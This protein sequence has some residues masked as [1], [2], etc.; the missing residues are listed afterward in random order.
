MPENVRAEIR[1]VSA[2]G[3]QFV[4][5]VPEGTP[6]GR[7]ADGTVIGENRV[8]MPQSIGPVLDQATVLMASIDDA[9]MRRVISES[10]DAFNG[11]ARDLQRF[12]DSA[13]L[14]LEEAQRNT[15]VTRKLIADAEP[16]LD[17][18]LRSSDSIRAWTRNLADVTDQ[19]RENEPQLTSLI[20]AAVPW[21]GL[22]VRAAATCPS[23][24]GLGSVGEVGVITA[25]RSGCW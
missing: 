16:V 12:I 14:L 9:K 15:D 7:L 5:F 19:L 11:S 8:D 17:S 25:P 6:E 18:Q 13:Q 22:R 24:G 2:V 21:A 20:Q 3:E 4:E 1:S 10:F 23:G